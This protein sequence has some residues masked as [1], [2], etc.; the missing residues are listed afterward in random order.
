MLEA[1]CIYNQPLLNPS[2]VPLPM[3]MQTAVALKSHRLKQK[4]SFE[5]KVEFLELLMVYLCNGQEL[6][7]LENPCEV[8]YRYQLK[9]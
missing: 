3:L 6:Q 7:A 1:I 9:L 5:K 2:L 4:Q 8:G